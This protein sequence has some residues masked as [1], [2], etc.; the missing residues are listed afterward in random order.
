MGDKKKSYKQKLMFI[1]VGLANTAIDFA[2]LNFMAAV[3]GVPRVWANIISVSVAM[4]F[5]YITNKELV[6]NSGKDGKTQASRFF[7]VTLFSLYIIQTVIILGLT[8]A[9]IWPL[10]QLYSAVQDIG[11]DVSEA[12]VQTN[13]SKLVATAASTVFNFIMYD[14]YVFKDKK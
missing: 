9:W 2:V 3:I 13:G 5:S 14:R 4:I 10:D 1:V 6:F 11:L 8:E 7:T 12:F